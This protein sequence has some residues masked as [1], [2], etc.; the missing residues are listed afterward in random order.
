MINFISYLV[1]AVASSTLKVSPSSF[2]LDGWSSWMVQL[3]WSYERERERK[4]HDTQATQIHHFILTLTDMTTY[5][6]KG[7]AWY[8]LISCNQITSTK[9][10]SLLFSLLSFF[11]SP[12]E[13]WICR[14]HN[15]VSL[16]TTLCWISS[17]L[18]TLHTQLSLRL[19]RMPS[20]AV[21]KKNELHSLSTFNTKKL[22]GPGGGV[23]VVIAMENALPVFAYTRPNCFSA[24]NIENLGI[25]GPGLGLGGRY[26]ECLH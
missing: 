24:C 1:K 18:E 23:K 7:R 5:P 21:N 6:G 17:P 13:L 25:Y 11:H 20:T 19:D 3:P 12:R 10:S 26:R 4:Q 9:W 14:E 16:D 8:A 2:L 15:P 22:G